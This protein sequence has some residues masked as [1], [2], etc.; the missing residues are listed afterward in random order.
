MHADGSAPAMIPK[1]FD[2]FYRLDDS[3]PDAD[4][5]SLGLGLYIA[6]E[7]IV[8]HG[9]TIEVRLSVNEGTAFTVRLPSA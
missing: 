1:L 5:T 8:A 6:K 4:S 3:K 2:S 9:G 7:I